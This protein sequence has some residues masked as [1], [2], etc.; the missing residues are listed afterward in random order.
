MLR[1]KKY[2]DPVLRRKTAVILVVDSDIRKLA[3]DML[4]V[5]YMVDGVG[6]AAPQVGISLRLCV[7]DVDL[8]KKSPVIM[9]NP[10][11]ISGEKR[12]LA[13]E[14]CLSFPGVSGEVM[15]F[16]NIIVR[17]IDLNRKVCV[18]KVQNLL[19]RAIQHEVDHLDGK[20]F[21]DYFS[22]YKR[23]NLEREIKRKK[24]IGEW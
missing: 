1:I 11:V 6:L 17:Y 3:L 7:V 2:G 4:E 13:W 19:A 21:I 10:E 12:V 20:L 5:M 23:K 9:V 18:I 15:R 22:W 14:G 16:C 8:N 24:K